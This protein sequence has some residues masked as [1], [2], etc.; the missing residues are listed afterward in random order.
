[1]L[2]GSEAASLSDIFCR[3]SRLHGFQRD[4][5]AHSVVE[6]LLCQQAGL[7]RFIMG[8]LMG[9]RHALLVGIEQICIT[10]ILSVAVF[11]LQTSVSRN[12]FFILSGQAI[13]L[14]VL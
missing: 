13:N 10:I 1:M 3:G 2:F 11:R 14:P 5:I 7:R 12:L 6:G 9:V 4:R 8:H